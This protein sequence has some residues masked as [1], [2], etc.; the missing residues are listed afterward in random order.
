M[1]A[2]YC[3]QCSQQQ[4]SEEMRFCSRCGFPLTGVRDLVAIGGVPDAPLK[5]ERG[6]AMRGVRQGVWI[7]LSAILVGLF[8]LVLTAIEDELAVLLL[9]PVLAILVGFVRTLYAVFVQER[10]ERKAS[11]L[12]Y[13]AP[14]TPLRSR[15]TNTPEL[16]AARAIPADTF[17]RPIKR[18]AEVAQPPSVTENTTRLLEDEGDSPHR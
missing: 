2:M 10:K 4:I 17:V 18:T 13:V 12:T 8:V 11:E 16:P 1:F 6:R 5:A 3:P 9:F 7:T 15:F 14:P